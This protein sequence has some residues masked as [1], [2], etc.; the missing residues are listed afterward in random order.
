MD[1][2]WVVRYWGR[3]KRSICTGI[4]DYLPKINPNVGT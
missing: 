3:V 4:P 2:K 1:R